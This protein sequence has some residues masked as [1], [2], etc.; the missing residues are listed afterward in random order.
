[1]ICTCFK[2]IALFQKR[3]PWYQ[4][5]MCHIRRAELRGCK[6]ESIYAIWAVVKG[7]RTPNT[8]WNLQERVLG[9]DGHAGFSK[10]DEDWAERVCDEVWGVERLSPGLIQNALPWLPLLLVSACWS[11]R[12]TS[13]L[14]SLCERSLVSSRST[15]RTTHSRLL[16]TLSQ[17]FSWSRKISAS[18]DF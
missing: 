1:M 16:S 12:K 3:T 9:L 10:S 18:A 5:E 13:S 2:I 4:A 15:Q 6:T 8:G 14:L 17:S 11:E 7:I